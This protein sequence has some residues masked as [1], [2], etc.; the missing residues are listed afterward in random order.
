MVSCLLDVRVSRCK[1]NPIEPKNRLRG[2][3]RPGD[4]VQPI[5]ASAL[6]EA[7]DFPEFITRSGLG[8]Y[9]RRRL[10]VNQSFTAWLVVPTRVEMHFI[11]GFNPRT[12]TKGRRS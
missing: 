12:T 3:R 7:F 1:N 5:V 6:K 2:L 8:I 4:P 10:P 9:E 11:S